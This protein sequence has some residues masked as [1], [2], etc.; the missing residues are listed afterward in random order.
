MEIKKMLDVANLV[1]Q[2][3]YPAAGSTGMPVGV[4]PPLKMKDLTL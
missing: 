2:S 1:I 4:V 3:H